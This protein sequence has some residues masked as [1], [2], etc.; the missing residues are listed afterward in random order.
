MIQV[1]VFWS[2]AMGCQFA[3]YADE[4]WHRRCDCP[5]VNRYFVFTVCFLSML[6][7]PSGTYLLN[8]FPAWET[9]FVYGRDSFG[10]NSWYGAL[11]PTVFTATNT[12]LGL[13][14]F[15]LTYMLLRLE[16]RRLAYYIFVTGYQLFFSIIG[17]GSARFMY[18]GTE[19]EFR[20]QVTKP[21]LQFWTSEVWISLCVMGCVFGPALMVPTLLWQ[22]RLPPAVL[23]QDR[24]MLHLTV[25][26]N[27]LL[28]CIGF[29]FYL[30]WYGDAE[31]RRLIS[32]FGGCAD[33]PFPLSFSWISFPNA[34]YFVQQGFG[35]YVPLMACIVF[36]YHMAAM[37]L[38]WT[39]LIPGQE[40]SAAAGYKSQ[41][42][43]HR[44]SKLK[45][46]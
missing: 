11:L 35:E 15:R 39:V 17:F 28:A 31:R 32:A 2:F 43:S 46:G 8:R 14:G 24:W 36:N 18:S 38:G 44:S 21:C 16:R 26:F 1:D 42:V 37:F 33:F 3:L 6:F 12:L 41:Q 22:S 25:A 45:E 4:G 7:A 29:E 40:Q 9:M 23:R 10:A 30:Q 5:Y 19:E 34:D 13:I 20:G 27:M